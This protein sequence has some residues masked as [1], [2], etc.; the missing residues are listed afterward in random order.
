MRS[1]MLSQ[2]RCILCYGLGLF[3]EE[4]DA[5]IVRRL[6]ATLVHRPGEA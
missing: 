2:G 5:G 4:E 6:A 3:N 1:V